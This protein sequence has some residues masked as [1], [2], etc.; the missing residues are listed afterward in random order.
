MRNIG[1]SL[2][3]DVKSSA[4]HVFVMP[5]IMQGINTIFMIRKSNYNN[6]ISSNKLNN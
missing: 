2:A 6:L 1:L 4:I 3:H 5:I